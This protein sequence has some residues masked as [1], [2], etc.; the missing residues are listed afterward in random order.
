MKEMSVV[1]F[2]TLIVAGVSNLVALV[3]NFTGASWVILVNPIAE[4]VTIILVALLSYFHVQRNKWNV[5]KSL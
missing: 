3:G 5:G 1:E 4:A 2:A